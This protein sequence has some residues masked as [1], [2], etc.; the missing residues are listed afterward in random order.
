VREILKE[1]HRLLDESEPAAL[2]TVI[3]TTGSA[4]RKEG[5]KMIC[6]EG[7]RLIGSISGGCL[8]SDVYERSVLVVERNQSE[9]VTYDTNAENENIWGLGLGC[10]GTVEVLIEPIGWWRSPDGREVFREMSQRVRDGQRCA[11][12]TMLLKDGNPVREVRRLLI[13]VRGA[14]HAS[15]GDR[16]LDAAVAKKAVQIL[17]EGKLRP[18]RRMNLTSEGSNY[19]VFVDA[20]LPPMRLFVFGAGH[21]ALPLV[22]MAR[23]IGMV[24]TVI[25]SRPQFTTQDRFPDADHL[26][27]VEAERVAEKVSFVGR[28][29]IVLMSHH[30]LKDL[31][32][33]R[34]IVESEEEFEYIGAL[35]PR[36]RTEQM[37][38]DLRRQG[39]KLPPRRV[40]SI[41]API[42][43][44][45][46]SESPAE[47]A[48]AVL[49][50]IL[51]AKNGRS[52]QP[53]RDK[54]LSSE[55]LDAP[56]HRPP[57]GK[58]RI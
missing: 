45:L 37:L 39:V 5:A 20:L 58:T 1:L 17:Q 56:T 6:R 10:N 43:L 49:A 29:A 13:D 25:D 44:D 12:A 53:L 23:E 33:L 57:E 48:L 7:G 52:A 11:I 38:E 36:A 15:F 30:Y 54:K 28:P 32:V 46:G 35:G 18:A 31:A 9:I 2:V 51:A 22:R 40:A 47:I 8:E 27:C 19:D 26:V 41:R 42:G 4:Y 50:E 34:Q 14:T 21:D 16:S 55:Q 24:V 3:G